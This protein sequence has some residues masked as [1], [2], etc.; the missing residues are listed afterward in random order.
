MLF[1]GISV[2]VKAKEREVPAGSPTAERRPPVPEEVSSSAGSLVAGM[3]VVSSLSGILMSLFGSI[4]GS[5]NGE[6]EV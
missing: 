5:R 4:C 3:C 2:G 6:V 1:G